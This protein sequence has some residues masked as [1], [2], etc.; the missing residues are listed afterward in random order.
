M[1]TVPSKSTSTTPPPRTSGHCSTKCVVQ[2]TQQGRPSRKSDS[3]FSEL[4][5]PCPA[6]PPPAPDHTEPGRKSTHDCASHPA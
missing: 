1:P 4:E 3:L 6:Q 2:S 5:N